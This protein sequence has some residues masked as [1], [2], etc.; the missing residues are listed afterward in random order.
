MELVLMAVVLARAELVVE[1]ALVVEV[2]GSE[3]VLTVEDGVVDEV[4]VLGDTVELVVVLENADEVVEL[5]V[6]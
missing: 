2:D 4:S 6:A 5:L 3:V 1:E